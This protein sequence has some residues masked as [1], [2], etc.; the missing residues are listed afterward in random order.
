[1]YKVSPEA[2]LLTP[3]QSILLFIT[4]IKG[5]TPTTFNHVI[6]NISDF[7]HFPAEIFLAGKCKKSEMVYNMF[8]IMLLF[9]STLLSEI[10]FLSTFLLY[11]FETFGHSEPTS[12]HFQVRLYLFGL[13]C[14]A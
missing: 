11:F 14:T 12:E 3:C 13:A 10:T 4:V 2:V 5:I 8:S 9:F 6:Y 7:L 1:V